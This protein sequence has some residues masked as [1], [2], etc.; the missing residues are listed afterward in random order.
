MLVITFDKQA[1]RRQAF[2]GKFFISFDYFSDKISRVLLL[3][4]ILARTCILFYT[5]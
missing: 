5:F 3:G 1:F 2:G 4:I